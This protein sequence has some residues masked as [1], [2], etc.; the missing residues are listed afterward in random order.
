MADT[1]K[2]MP[3]LHHYFEIYEQWFS[4]WRGREDVKLLEIGVARGGS[5]RMWRQYFH[6]GATIVGLDIDPDCKVHENAEENLFVEIGDQT[7]TS[8][9]DDV[10]EKLGP[11][12]IIVDDGGHT[13]AQQTISFN[14]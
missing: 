12:D 1:D 2:E 5:L 6:P 7:D 11:F 4:P 9:L 14:H 13:P 8:F 3:K 10:I